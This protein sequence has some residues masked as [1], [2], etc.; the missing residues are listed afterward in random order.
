MNAHTRLFAKGQVVVPKAVRD[1]WTT[2]PKQ[3]LAQALAQARAQVCGAATPA[4]A[5]QA[6]GFAATRA[7][8]VR[9]SMVRPG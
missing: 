2:T 1:P 9:Q 7:S 8:Q 4:A 3:A 6:P 5:A